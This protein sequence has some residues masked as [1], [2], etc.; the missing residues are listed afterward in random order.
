MWIK[1]NCKK[2]KKALTRELKN[3]LKKFDTDKQS[4]K[5]KPIGDDYKL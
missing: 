3:A 2:S 4:G 5:L 1:P